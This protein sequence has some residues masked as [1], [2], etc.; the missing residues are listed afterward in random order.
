MQ[1]KKEIKRNFENNVTLHFSLSIW[2]PFYISLNSDLKDPLQDGPNG[3]NCSVHTPVC[4]DQLRSWSNWEHNIKYIKQ[5]QRLYVV[6][7]IK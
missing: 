6:S 7:S 5:A 2:V 1:K 3:L 4:Q